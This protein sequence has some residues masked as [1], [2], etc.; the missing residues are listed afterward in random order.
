[1]NAREQGSTNRK[2]GLPLHGEIIYLD[3]KRICTILVIS[4]FAMIESE[5]QRQAGNDDIITVD[6]KKSYSQKKN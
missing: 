2:K 3:M 5:G 6:V 1:M 4:F